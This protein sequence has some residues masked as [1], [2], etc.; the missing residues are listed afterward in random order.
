VRY[1]FIRYHGNY[2]SPYTKQPYGIFA[3]ISHL[4]RDG[5]LSKADSDLY[6]KTANWFEQNLPNPPF[7]DDRNA[8]RAVTWFKEYNEARHMIER[9]APF[10]EIAQKYEVEIIKSVR[11]EAPG[12]IVYEDEYQVGVVDHSERLL[13]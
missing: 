4:Q 2:S 12:K 5:K 1:L 7:Y 3:V 10:F 6:D 8:I 13:E 9:L 11:Y